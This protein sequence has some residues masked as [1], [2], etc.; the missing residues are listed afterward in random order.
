MERTD[1]PPAFTKADVDL[2]L[3]LQEYL[4][5]GVGFHKLMR[6]QADIASLIER[7]SAHAASS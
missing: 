7:V 1:E 2:L 6:R 5:N 4:F 3:D